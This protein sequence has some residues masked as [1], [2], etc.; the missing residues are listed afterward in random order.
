MKI[1]DLHTLLAQWEHPDKEFRSAP[2][3]GWNAFLDREN[4]EFQIGEM[5]KEGMGGFFVHSREGLETP[6]LSG[7]WMDALAL[8]VDKASEEDLEVWIYDED[9]WPSGSA[10]GMVSRRNPD[11]YAAKGLTLEILPPE[12][13]PCKEAGSLGLSGEEAAVD[14]K[15]LGI[16]DNV[17]EGMVL[18]LRMERSGASE[19]YNGYAPTDNLNPQAVS[20][21]IQMTHGRYKQR[22]G[23]EFGKRIKG[24]FTDEPNC[25]DFFS[26]FTKG[27]PWLVWTE[28]FPRVFEEKRGYSPM[29]YLPYLFIEGKESSRIR[30]DYWRTVTELF[31]ESYMK[32]LYQWCDE[33]SLSMTGH[34]L[35]ENDLGYNIRVCGAAMPLYR[36]MHCPGIDILG[37]QTREYLTVKQC[38]SVAN[39]YGR[40]IVLSETYGCT[41]WEFTFEGQKWL[42]DWQFVMGVTRR[43]QHL[44]QYS[45]TGCRKRDYPPVF[46]Y[47]TTWWEHNHLM[48]TYFARLSACVTTGEVV[49]HVLV[50]HPI[51]SLW[52]MCKSSPEEDLDHIEMNMGWLDSHITDLNRLGEEYNRLANMLLGAHWDFDFGDEIILGENASVDN[53]MLRVG[54]RRYDTVVVPGVLSLFKTTVDLLEGF[55][56]AG[57][58][59]IWVGAFPRMIE[60]RPGCLAEHVFGNAPIFR[61]TSFEELL[62]VLEQV[63]PRE[64]RVEKKE[65]GEDTQILTMLRKTEDGY[66]VFAVN[67]DR[68][69]EHPVTFSLSVRGKVEVL[70]LWTGEKWEKEVERSGA[71][72]A[73]VDTFRP[74]MSRI[75]LIHTKEAPK[76]G[77]QAFPYRHPHYTDPVFAALGP[78]AAF[79]RTAPNVLTLDRCRYCLDHGEWSD[80]MEVWQAQRRI[81]EQLNMQQVYY[82]GAPQRY[83]WINDPCKTDGTAFALRFEFS[84]EALPETVCYG[85]IEKPEGYLVTCN[86]MGCELADGYFMDRD[87]KKIRLN[88]LKTGKNI[89]EITGKYGRKVELEDSYIIGDFGVNP[90]RAITA[91]PERIH[92]GDW[93]FQGYYHYAGSMVYHFDLPGKMKDSKRIIL[94]LGQYRGTLAGILVNGKKAGYL[95]GKCYRDLDITDHLGEKENHLDIEVVGSPR[96]MFGPFHQ[97]YTGCTRISW[98]DFR[99]EGMYHCS[100]YVLEPYGLMEQITLYEV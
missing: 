80:E 72:M 54:I 19:W 93:C 61:C 9:K 82:N 73:F 60:G 49:R 4:L 63:Q 16:Y 18:V 43:C 69:G 7:E 23:A 68:E 38:T 94:H 88:G 56:K 51:T 35:Y 30:H 100:G 33:N 76:E 25:C 53:K 77:K 26:V 92:F 66:L 67:H 1:A 13:L 78:E 90:Q 21:F 12:I 81:R 50:L 46:N 42:G 64:V 79:S 97:A 48:E 20:E 2:F 11:Q 22:F 91:E 27:R 14:G 59:L 87:M 40:T 28:D 24:F 41:G 17:V 99:T 6:Y 74:A 8:C 47:Q 36:F 34:V 75:Y 70:D 84:V 62:G 37:E 45:I 89:L 55:V 86:G 3:W 31:S 95:M 85:V 15:I 44:A 10:G 29:E 52:T 96:N 65:G 98:K 57:G 71:G 39:Q 83:M 58:R 5:K 32:Q